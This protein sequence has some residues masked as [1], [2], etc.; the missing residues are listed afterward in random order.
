[1]EAF[2]KNIIHIRKAL[3]IRDNISLMFQTYNYEFNFSIQ[4][5]ETYNTFTKC[6]GI[7][8]SDYQDYLNI[9]FF[10]TYFNSC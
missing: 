10:K 1:M 8:D 5:Y 9:Y 7:S 4:I 6:Y 3:M 2:L